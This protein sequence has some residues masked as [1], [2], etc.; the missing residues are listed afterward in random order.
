MSRRFVVGTSPGVRQLMKDNPQ[1]YHFTGAPK[2][3]RVDERPARRA[4]RPTSG[5]RS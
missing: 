1:G 3:V 4:P 2:E 5:S